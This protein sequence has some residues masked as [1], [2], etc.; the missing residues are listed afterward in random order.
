MKL[1]GSVSML[2]VALA[3]PALAQ[4]VAPVQAVTPDAD[5]P[6]RE[7][8]AGSALHGLSRRR[9]RAPVIVEHDHHDA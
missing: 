3:S 2:G 4:M 7:A 8:P 5:K 1:L 9:S 6:A